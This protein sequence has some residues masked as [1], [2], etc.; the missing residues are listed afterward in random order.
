M[1]FR[2]AKCPNVTMGNYTAMSNNI[3]T[4]PDLSKLKKNNQKTY[5]INNI[6]HLVYKNLK[7]LLRTT[8]SYQPH[9]AMMK[10]DHSHVSAC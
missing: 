5:F 3:S 8:K 9:L 10:I 6:F 7:R 2:Y 4:I 1:R